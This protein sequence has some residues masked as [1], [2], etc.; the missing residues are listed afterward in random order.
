MFR[1]HLMRQKV[2]E[3]WKKLGMTREDIGLMLDVDEIPSREFLKA[4][5]ICLPADE[6]LIQNNKFAVDWR[7][8]D[9][10]T[11]YSPLLRLSLTMFEGSPKCIHKEEGKEVGPRYKNKIFKRFISTSMIIGACIEGIGN[12]TRHIKI[13][14]VNKDIYGNY[15]GGRTKGYGERRD[16]SKLIPEQKSSSDKTNNEK[17]FK[18]FYYPLYNSADFRQMF[19][20][21]TQ[22]LWRFGASHGYHLHNF[23]DSADQIRFKYAH[24]G[25]V[26]DTAFSVPLGGLNADMSLFVKCAHNISD[27]ENRKKRINQTD[28]VSIVGGQRH[29]IEDHL[30]PLVFHTLKGYV[31]AR[32]EEMVAL[33]EKD[34]EIY[35]RA[36]KF[37]GNHLY[38]DNMLTHPGKIYNTELKEEEKTE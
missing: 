18:E 10:Q 22:P 5:Q 12:S 17:E 16:Y 20:V 30:E 36:D 25:H 2:L 21:L 11:C 29:M 4:A 8:D 3:T 33:V 7:T 27:A 32:H 13:P 15:Q 1:E 37:D 24:F 38:K 23:F 34:E 9:K 31:D 26:H 28:L 14:R 35:G 6:K 19:K